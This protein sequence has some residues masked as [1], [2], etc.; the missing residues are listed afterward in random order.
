M[1]MQ[2]MHKKPISELELQKYS[3]DHL[4]PILSEDTMMFVL[5]LRHLVP[6]ERWAM[7]IAPPPHA[8]TSFSSHHNLMAQ[9]ASISAGIQA[10]RNAASVLLDIEI[11]DWAASVADLGMECIEKDGNHVRLECAAPLLRMIARS[12][13]R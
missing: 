12:L 3:A 9:P 6:A 8:S 4:T 2:T 11:L 13:Q 1:W 5:E 10:V 7:V